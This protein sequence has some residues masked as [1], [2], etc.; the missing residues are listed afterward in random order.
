[1]KEQ[2]YACGNPIVT[3]LRT[4]HIDGQSRYYCR[5]HW[6]LAIV[7]DMVATGVHTDFPQE[8]AQGAD[9]EYRNR[10]V[11]SSARRDFDTSV[12]AALS[13]GNPWHDSSGSV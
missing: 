10:L 2:C 8:T 3:G 12:K 9:S 6:L 13:R 1:M 7:R 5:R 4:D 11:W